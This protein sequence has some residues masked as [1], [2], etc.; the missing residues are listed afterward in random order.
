MKRKKKFNEDKTPWT[1]LVGVEVSRIKKSRLNMAS[2]YW[3]QEK[4]HDYATSKCGFKH[5]PYD[6][7]SQIGNAEEWSAAF[8]KFCKKR[9]NT[10]GQKVD[11]RAL[12][13]YSYNNYKG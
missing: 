5:T 6:Q 12:L 9:V 13:G 4:V 8:K 2:K 3:K 11:R 1:S 10:K 7:E